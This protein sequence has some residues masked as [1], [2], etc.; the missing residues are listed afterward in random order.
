MKLLKQLIIVF[1]ICCIGNLI[2]YF[3]PIPFPGS[4]LALILLFLC[5]YFKVV[6]PSQ[7]SDVSDFLLHNMTILFIPATVSIIS[8]VDILKKFLIPF[9]VICFVST[10]IVFFLTAFTVK[11]V[12]FIMNKRRS[13]KNA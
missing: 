3:L 11:L 1:I 12:I 7:I 10:V 6:K 13:K 2:S 9:L 5:M 8:Y 4:V